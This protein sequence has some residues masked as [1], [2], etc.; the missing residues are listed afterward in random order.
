MSSFKE[1][2]VALDGV[3]QNAHELTLPVVFI[4]S[5]SAKDSRWTERYPDL[6]VIE[7][8]TISD[9]SSFARLQSDA[10]GRGRK[11]G[12]T[13][14]RGKMYEVA[15]TDLQSR[16]IGILEEVY[17]QVR[18]RID[19]AVSGSP[20]TNNTFLGSMRGEIYG[21]SHSVSRF[22]DFTWALRPRQSISGLY[23]SGQD[24]VCDGIAGAL[25]AGV[26]CAIA[27]DTRVILD[28]IVSYFVEIL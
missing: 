13:G 20:L 18:G 5:S 27:I 21:L 24:V 22:S 6:S 17:P 16:L 3:S 28:I 12:K 2:L 9:F 14:H 26:L 4:G 11:E 23:L 8:L 10:L 15:K 7:I 19:L 25:S 1:S